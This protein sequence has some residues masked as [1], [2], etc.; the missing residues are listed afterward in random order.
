M[1]FTKQNQDYTYQH[2][3]QRQKIAPLNVSAHTF[4]CFVL[5]KNGRYKKLKGTPI[6]MELATQFTI[7]I[8]KNSG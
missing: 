4:V 7:S 2:T 8:L 6:Y 5:A 3:L 1:Y